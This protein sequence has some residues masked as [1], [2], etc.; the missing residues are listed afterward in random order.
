MEYKQSND[1]IKINN[2]KCFEH[3]GDKFDCYCMDFEKDLCK[4]CIG[5]IHH[6]H[7]TIDL[8][9]NLRNQLI[10]KINESIDI[11]DNNENSNNT[12]KDINNNDNLNKN[13]NIIFN[14]DNFSIKNL[15]KHSKY[16]LKK[17]L[18]KLKVFYS[19]YPCYNID[20][21]ITNISKFCLNIN[22]QKYIIKSEP[23]KTLDI[24]KERKIRFPWEFNRVS[25]DEN[26]ISIHLIE[27]GIKN[28]VN[29]TKFNLNNLEILNLKNNN[30]TDIS[31]LK[32]IN[33]PNLKALCLEENKITDEN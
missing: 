2:I 33:F 7:T 12:Q 13:N 5:E 10:E 11:G 4:N 9:I 19:I 15:D 20:K 24:I 22:E 14:Q 8:N 21:S 27:Q 17:L 3:N 18:D 1:I 23:L 32:S 25:E 6:N 16:S 31:P 28:I 26:I 30:I 29:L